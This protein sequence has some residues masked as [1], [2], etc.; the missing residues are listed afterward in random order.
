MEYRTNN[1]IGRN[2][3]RKETSVQSGEADEL[4]FFDSFI[5]REILDVAGEYAGIIKDFIFSRKKGRVEYVVVKLKN[6]FNFFRKYYTIPFNFVEYRGP[7]EPIL[8]NVTRKTLMQGPKFDRSQLKD[9]FTLHY[10]VISTYWGGLAG[11][12]SRSLYNHF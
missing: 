4:L 9:I 7:Y 12:M 3:F 1:D 5:N 6:P 11:D 2:L 10:D 8:L